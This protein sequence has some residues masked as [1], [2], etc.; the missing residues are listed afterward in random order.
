MLRVTITNEVKIT[1][2]LPGMTKLTSVIL[3]IIFAVS[4]IIGITVGISFENAK[5][6]PTPTVWTAPQTGHSI[7]TLL[8]LGVNNFTDEEIYLESAWLVTITQSHSDGGN[9]LDVILVGIYPGAPG[10]FSNSTQSEYLQPHAPI[11][12]PRAYL[13]NLN[14]YQMLNTDPDA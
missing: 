14:A 10:G 13:N 5:T 6:T 3:I 11:V 2:K 9:F 4:L 12:F 8:V 7:G 1:P